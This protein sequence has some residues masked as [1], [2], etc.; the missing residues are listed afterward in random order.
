LAK[1]LLC[2]GLHSIKGINGIIQVVHIGLGNMFPS[3]VIQSK[4]KYTKKQL[5]NLTQND[6]ISCLPSIY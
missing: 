1:V 2:I 5:Y 6:V 3:L 4:E